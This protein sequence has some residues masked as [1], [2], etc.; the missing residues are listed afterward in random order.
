MYRYNLTG[1]RL[2]RKLTIIVVLLG[3]VSVSASTAIKLYLSYKQDMKQVSLNFDLIEASYINSLINN[4]WVYNDQQIGIQLDG[5]LGLPGIEY[6]NINSEGQIVWSSGI[7]KSKNTLEKKFELIYRNGSQ[8]KSLGTLLVVAGL[9]YIYKDLFAGT[10]VALLISAVTIFFATGFILLI[11]RNMVTRHLTKIA[12]F[13]NTL[14][15][16]QRD[17][18]LCLNRSSSPG[19]KADELDDVVDAINNMRRNLLESIKELRISEEKFRTLVTNIE[20]IVYMIDKNGIF[21]L[22]EGKGL[23]ALGLKQ[24]QVVGKSVFEL[25]KDYPDMLEKMQK[26]LNGETV[27]TEVNINGIYFRS[28]YTPHTNPEGEIIGLIGLSVNI[29]RQ[30]QAEVEKEKLESR[31]LQVQ[32]M[33]AIGTLAGG[34]AHDF[35]NI[36]S[37]L[38]GYAEMLQEDLPENSPEQ[39]SITEVLKAA[40]RAR[41][42]V[43]Q[44]LT[45]SRQVNQNIKPIKVQSILK[46]VL[47]LLKSSIPKTIDIQTK[48]DHDCGG[49]VADP[50]QIHQLIMNLATNAYHAMQE[51]G[52]QLKIIFKQTLIDSKPLGFDELMP[53]QYALLKVIDTGMGIKKDVMDKIFDPYFTTKSKDKGT[54]L[55]LSVVQGIVKGCNGYI[56][57]YSES[58]QGTEVHVY[59]PITKKVS[60]N[61]KPDPLQPIRGGSELILLV[62]DEKSIVKMEQQMLER[63]GYE[64]VSRTGSIE[65]LDAFKENPDKFD[66]IIS[67]MTMPD[68]TGVQLAKEVKAIRTDIPVIICT[69]FSDHISEETSSE[70]GIQGY[71]A[72]P[73]VKRQIAQLIR[74]VLDKSDD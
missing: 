9:D 32:K 22:S 11:F 23:C 68:M 12:H 45:F 40:L 14:D 57:I 26:A 33:E 47:K 38:L 17:A 64:I 24:G 27:T 63:L 10:R 31:L 30:K 25:Y 59:L 54:G 43:K 15:M 51:S 18:V 16:K 72:K 41:D 71:V 36:L 70:F 69:G 29:T 39:E 49:V 21:L 65:A 34:I 60:D 67:D 37:P 13:V 2:A 35:N 55:G 8:H 53:G 4:I 56:H 42:L 46:E 74:E 50:T 62:D 73:V 7:I 44:I 19:K 6:V 5:M 66:L 1:S 52:G 28:W 20:E 3:L 61:V 58:D 48:I